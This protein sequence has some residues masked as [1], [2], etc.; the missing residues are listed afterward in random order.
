MNES[1]KI[2]VYFLRPTSIKVSLALSINALSI[3]MFREFNR[4]RKYILG[5]ERALLEPEK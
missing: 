3:L 5:L 1:M 2:N 4:D